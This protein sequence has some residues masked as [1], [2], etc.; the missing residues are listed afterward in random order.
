MTLTHIAFPSLELFSSV[1]SRE[2]Y[3]ET[4]RT[5]TFGAK[6]KLHGTNIAIRVMPDGSVIAQSRKH[7]L[8]T[9]KDLGDFT[10]FL[11]PQKPLWATAS[12]CQPLTFFGEWAGPGINKGDAVQRTDKKRFYIFAVGIGTM[13]H[14]QTDKK[15]LPAWMITDPETITSMLPNGL[16]TDRVRVLPWEGTY[17]FDFSNSLE[18]PLDLL[19]TAVDAIAI[20]DP[21]IAREFNVS[22][23]GEGLVL[24]E[25]SNATGMLSGANYG[26]SSF[27]AK[28]E[29]HRV[30]K[31]G[32]PAL[33]KAP[34]PPSAKG[35]S[36]AYV[37]NPRLD[38]AIDELGL[39]RLDIKKTGSIIGW[40]LAD[41]EKEGQDDL[42]DIAL[43]FKDVSSML[44]S[45]IRTLW[46]KR[47]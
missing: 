45:D 12:I 24:V 4:P 8:S 40:M 23:S 13:E 29:R 7:D 31:Q 36:D 15:Q 5:V 6:I 46:M 35:F 16:D 14:P 19:N 28:V 3:P 10:P 25:Q 20:E 22:H 27:K 41:I 21:Y 43:S 34:L 44:K 9:E 2:T 17:T 30:R 42:R 38:Q 26:R 47:L 1:V 37:T 18:T 33:E 11:E 32:K 39:E